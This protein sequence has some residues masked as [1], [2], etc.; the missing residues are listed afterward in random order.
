MQFEI[1]TQY[2]QDLGSAPQ[3]TSTTGVAYASVTSAPAGS[4]TGLSIPNTQVK[5]LRLSGVTLTAGQK[6]EITLSN[7]SFPEVRTYTFPVYMR[8]GSSDTFSNGSALSADG[9]TLEAH[10]NGFELNWGNAGKDNLPLTLKVLSVEGKGTLAVTPGPIFRTGTVNN[11]QF[12][13]TAAASTGSILI[14]VP[15]NFTEPEMYVNPGVTPLV[16]LTTSDP[17]FV[18]IEQ[19]AGTLSVSGQD[20]MVKEMSLLAGQTISVGY[21]QATYDGDQVGAVTFN[22]RASADA[23]VLG[24]G[25]NI[26]A[27]DLTTADSEPTIYFVSA[28]GIG[29]VTRYDG[30]ADANRT[31]SP[32]SGGAAQTNDNGIRQGVINLNGTPAGSAATIDFYYSLTNDEYIKNGELELVIPT[33]W[34]QPAKGAYHATYNDA[35]VTINASLYTKASPTAAAGWVNFVEADWGS[36][37]TVSGRSIIVTIA[38]MSSLGA[39][40]DILKV[41][42]VGTAPNNTGDSTVTLRQRSGNLDIR[43]DIA[44]NSK[45]AQDATTPITGSAVR[46]QTAYGDADKGT[47]TSSNHAASIA[48]GSGPY[49]F[50]FTYTTPVEVDPATKLHLRIPS[51]RTSANENW[52][53]APFKDALDG[54]LAGEITTSTLPVAVAATASTEAIIAGVLN[55]A[56]NIASVTTGTLK[57]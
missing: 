38:E 32:A 9:N 30:P 48:A 13:F 19:G 5:Y 45:L 15:A 20:I 51:D 55:V 47:V 37:I 35:T 8:Y 17:G 50:S 16:S 49:T 12:Q 6:I 24:S 40:D 44:K 26:N 2:V 41:S 52:T 57:A 21:Y 53:P 3:A 4:Y 29:M 7:L 25:I 27:A 23:T 42:Y 36:N 18:R 43:T 34:T 31:N 56:G 1:P 28:D 46:L 54:V 11:Y 33:D 22:A 39:E 14:R 10:L